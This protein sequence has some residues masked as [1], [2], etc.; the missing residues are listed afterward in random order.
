VRQLLSLARN[1]PGAL[2]TV[3]LQPLDLNAFALEVSMEWVPHAIKRNIDLG[4]EGV[5]QPLTDRRRPRPAA[6]AHQQPDRQ[7]DPLQPV[8]RARHGARQ[9]HGAGE[10]KLAIS[11]DGPS[12]PV[13]ERQRIFE[14]FH[15]LLGNQEDGS[16][17]GLA[18]VSEIAI[19]HR[20][21]I[22]LEEDLHDGVGNTF[23]VLFPAPARCLTASSPAVSWLKAG[24]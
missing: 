2:D 21:K 12:I 8:R 5:E 20:A 22:E 4:F 14:R 13:A 7:R 6:R 1:E 19:L 24:V 10:C 9:P 11:D 3:Q 18:I 15:R 17:L 23:S 16:G